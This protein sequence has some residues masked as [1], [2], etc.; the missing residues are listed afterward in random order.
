MVIFMHSIA[1]NC[2]TEYQVQKSKFITYLFF[3]T[4]IQEVNQ[5]LEQIHKEHLNAT[6]HCYAYIIDTQKRCSDD[7][8]PSGTAGLP[9]LN[10]LEKKNMNFILCIVVRY[11]GGI[12]LGTGGLVRAYTN[13]VTQALEQTNYIDVA[14]GKE[15]TL[16]FS[17]EHKQKIDS[18]LQDIALLKADYQDKI[19][20]HIQV[21]N[22]KWE[23]IKNQI[24]VYLISYQ[25]TNDHCYVK[26]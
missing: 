6:H 26:K 14:L 3:V 7:G 10:V 2:I 17:Y 24:N 5:Y 9:I 15:I 13:S 25:I 18:I 1:Q 22:I 23:K 19:E 12:L 20:Y 11:F 4:S 16:L 21:E 8:E